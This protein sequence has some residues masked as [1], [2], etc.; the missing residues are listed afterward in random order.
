[1]TVAV[2]LC[3][4]LQVICVHDAPNIYHVPLM[5]EDQGVMDCLVERLKLD[6]NRFRPVS[7]GYGLSNAAFRRWREL[8]LRYGSL[9]LSD[10]S[11]HT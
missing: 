3:R 10:E 1:M 8:A 11:K 9:L 6:E 5:L 4:C 7:V 2:A